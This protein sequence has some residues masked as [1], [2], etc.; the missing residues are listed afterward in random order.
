L[1]ENAQFEVLM[2]EVPDDRRRAESAQVILNHRGNKEK[3][4]KQNRSVLL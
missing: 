4:L 2:G 1:V 3:G